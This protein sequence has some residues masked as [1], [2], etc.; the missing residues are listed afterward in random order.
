MAELRFC[1]A[2]EAVSRHKVLPVPVGLSRRAFF[3][4]AGKKK[5]RKI[6]RARFE[7]CGRCGR[8]YQSERANQADIS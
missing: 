1:Q 5:N 2:N 8:D 4:S 3:C 7:A 6:V